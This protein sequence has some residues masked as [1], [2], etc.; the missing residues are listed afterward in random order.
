MK[1]IQEVADMFNVHYQ[2]IR[3]WIK[4]GKIKVFKVNNTV[5]ISDEEIKKIQ[6][7]QSESPDSK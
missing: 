7:V 3:N 1:T 6:K 5:R 4:Q 2:T